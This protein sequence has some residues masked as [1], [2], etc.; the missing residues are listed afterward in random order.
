M[1]T[2]QTPTDE[3]SGEEETM[4]RQKNKKVA[5]KD[6]EKQHNLQTSPT[7]ERQG[8]NVNDG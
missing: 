5:T 8:G 7:N 3:G 4:K 6:C 1:G 2:K